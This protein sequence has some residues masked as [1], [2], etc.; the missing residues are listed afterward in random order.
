MESLWSATVKSENTNELTVKRKLGAH[1]KTDVLIIGGGMAGI[2]TA[3]KLKEAGIDCI[4]VEAAAIGSGITKNTTAKITAQHGLIYAHIIKRYGVEKAR[5]YYDANAKAIEAFAK[6]SQTGSC[7]FRRSPAFVYTTNN[8]SKIEEEARAYERLKLPGAAF[9]D[10][11]LPLPI[12]TKGALVMENQARFNPLKLLYALGRSLEIYENT[13]IK[14]IEG[15]KAVAEAGSISAEHI[16]LATHFPF[17]NIPGLYFMKLYQHRSYCIALSGAPD[18]GGMYID[19]KEDGLSF[20]NYGDLLII[21]GGDH[22]T[23]K[24][25]GAY[26]ELRSLAASAYPEAAEKYHWATQDAMSLDFIPY[27]GRHSRWY[28]DLYVATGFN[29]WG[30]TGSMVSAGILCDLILRGKSEYEALYSPNRPI[31]NRQ[32]MVNAGSAAAGLLSIGGPRCSHMGCKLK[33][34]SI[35]KTWDCSCHGSRFSEKG[36][37]RDNP[38]KKRIR[39]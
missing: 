11:R 16:V 12:K 38:A 34:N 9:T 32:L 31:L 15:S 20:R 30:M 6:L 8:P 35:E 18:I 14:H 1:K 36:H 5:L 13:F 23:G 10:E 39:L 3:Y 19:E 33:W 24:K 7:D 26:P 4:V 29:K 2:L 28:P 17:I 27:I 21:G 37:V 25:G 22:K